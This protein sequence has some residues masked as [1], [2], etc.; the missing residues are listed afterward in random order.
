MEEYGTEESRYKVRLHAKLN[1]GRCRR[2]DY[3]DGDC[4]QKKFTALW[5]RM[6]TFRDAESVPR[7][8]S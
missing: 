8:L 3:D 4:Q 7:I 1:G 6:H 5:F 2:R